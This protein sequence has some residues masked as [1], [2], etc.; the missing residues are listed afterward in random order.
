[1]VMAL[2]TVLAV[3]LAYLL[4]PPADTGTGAPIRSLAVLPFEELSEGSV[5][6]YFAAGLTEALI[7]RLTRLEELRVISPT[8]VETF[9]DSPLAATDIAS[10]LGVAAVLEGSVV[11]AGDRV[12]VT[13][14]LVDGGTGTYLWSDEFDQSMSDIL[15]LQASI[16]GAVV[17]AVE[18]E[19]T[20]R[21]ESAISRSPPVNSEAYWLYLRGRFHWNRRTIED[22]EESRRAFER[23]I[24][25]APELAVAHSGLADAYA[26]LSTYYALTPEEAFPPARRA[27]QRA[28]EL[29]PDLA[30]AHASLGYVRWIEWDFVGAEASYRRAIELGPGYATA[31]Q[32]YGELLSVL[33]RHDEALMSSERALA[34]DPLSPLINAAHG[35]RLNAAGRFEEALEHFRHALD[36]D[37]R[38]AWLRR[39]MA[40]A[41]TQLGREERA[42][43]ERLLEMEARGVAEGLLAELRLQ[44]ESEGLRGFWRWE[45]GRL[46]R[47][48]ASRFVPAILLAEASEGSG[49]REAALAY[50]DEATVE[51]G[52]HILQLATSPELLRLL[53][54]ARVRTLLANSGL[55]DIRDTRP[56]EARR[57]GKGE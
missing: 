57:G 35:Q 29:D 13:A 20:V 48:S 49:D 17:A 39:E 23:A 31:H 8:S 44:V 51:R 25:L 32:W 41:E 56:S 27:A 55:S 16:A 15:H 42:V 7:T 52:D 45:L 47:E 19:L 24:E 5:E 53:E 40:Y 14:H 37:S 1:M 30:E 2:A 11:Q 3:G 28:V 6:P 38:F 33:G 12:R 46:R 21:E 43:A 50:L 9:R 22:L 54:D 10:E 34:L 4:R 26:L 36:L 18:L